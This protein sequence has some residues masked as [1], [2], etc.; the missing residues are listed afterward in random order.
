MGLLGTNVGDKF[1]AFF[2]PPPS[3]PPYSF[4]FLSDLKTQLISS[5]SYSPV[6]LIRMRH[7]DKW[8]AE[9]QQGGWQDEKEYLTFNQYL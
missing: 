2:F 7:I 9:M 1:K 8:G 4:L 3:L 6:S 5:P